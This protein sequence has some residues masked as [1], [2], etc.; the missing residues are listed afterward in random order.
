MLKGIVV[1]SVIVS[2]VLLSGCKEETKSE[3]WYNHH[4]NET[5][6]V[7]S[8]CLKTGE[9][10]DNCEFARRAAIGF[11]QL[12]TEEQKAKFAPLMKG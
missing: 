9:A 8:K 5:F 11:Y 4:P 3:D 12:G 1:A 10:S 2:V 7:Y 6:N